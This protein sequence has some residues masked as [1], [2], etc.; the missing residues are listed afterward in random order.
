[1]LLA[2][3]NTCSRLLPDHQRRQTAASDGEVLVFSRISQVLA[4]RKARCA[5]L[6]SVR[7]PSAGAL[8]CKPRLGVVHLLVPAPPELTLHPPCTQHCVRLWPDVACALSSRK[9]GANM[10]EFMKV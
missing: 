3:Y 9:F 4:G 2:A 5:H 6:E 8:K 10:L 1:M 7:L